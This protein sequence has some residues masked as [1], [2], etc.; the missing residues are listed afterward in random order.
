MILYVIC[1]HG[2]GDPGAVGNGYQEA[3]RVRTL[4]ARMAVLG[5]NSVRLCDTSRNW[6]ADNGVSTGDFGGKDD[7]VIELH[8]DSYGTPSPHGGHVIIKAGIGGADKYDKALAAFL[9]SYFP[10]RSDT[11]VER[12]DLANLNRAAARGINYRWVECCFISNPSD[13][14]KFNANLD[15]V[16]EGLLGA[17]GIG[18]ASEPE[19]EPEPKPSTPKYRVRKSF[20][21]AKS[22]VGAYN[23]FENAKAMAESKAEKTY[24]FKVFEVATGRQVYP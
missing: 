12:N 24:P 23:D 14:A 17:F 21:D 5:G 3:E 13:M 7:A 8:L 2:A 15:A 22:Q 10:G 20:D 4:G 9:G 6:Y 16:A 11:I 19:P 1:G 18:V